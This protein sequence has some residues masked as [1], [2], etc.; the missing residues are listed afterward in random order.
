METKDD[1]FE[2]VEPSASPI[3][4]SLRAFGYTPETAIADLVDNSISAKATRIDIEFSWNGPSSRVIVTDNG[5]GMTEPK[6]VEAMRLGSTS[7]L[8]HRNKG[9]L[10]RFGLGLKTASFSQARELTVSSIP[11]GASS[12]QSIRR[13]DLDAVVET[14]EWRLLRNASKQVQNIIDERQPETGTV[15]VLGKLDRLLGLSD[16]SLTEIEPSKIHFLDT[17]AKVAEH[18]S[19]VF[20]RFLG[21]KSKPIEIYVNNNKVHAWDPFLSANVST[22][23]PGKEL[24]PLAGHQIAI[25]PYVLPHKSKLTESEHE[26]AAGPNGWNASQGFY[27][28]REDRLLVAGTWLGIGGVK[29]EHSKLARIALDIP[30]ELDHLW[31]VDV[32]KSSIKAPSAIASE[33]L[34]IAKLTKKHAQQV[35]RFRGKTVSSKNTKDFVVAWISQVTRDKGTTYKLNRKH[36]LVETAIQDGLKPGPE[37]ETLLK[38]VEE[39]MPITQIGISVSE[40]LDST[41]IPFEGGTSEL[42]H[43]LKFLISRLIYRGK[44]KAEAIEFLGAS[45]PYSHFPSILEAMK[46]SD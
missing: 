2:I 18:L 13:W 22:W 43:Q 6:L 36:P 12:Q 8:T 14:N 25:Q 9:D 34:R 42:E 32:R 11:K 24:I 5:E 38:F 35:Y 44:T 45:E 46:D 30:S 3:L 37:I 40:S 26:K 17:A 41:H 15:L 27:V 1:D 16:Q 21:R 29:E 19:M 10:G 33:L 28:Y 7:P 31:Q 39:T 4:E 20:H 23:S